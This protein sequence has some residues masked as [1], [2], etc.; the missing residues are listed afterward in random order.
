MSSERHYTSLD[1]FLCEAQNFLN[2]GSVKNHSASRQNPANR[3]N[4]HALDDAEKNLSA[5]LMRVN[6]AGEVAAQGLY[7]GQSLTAKTQETRRQMRDAAREEGDHLH[8]CA[9]R[10]EELDSHTSYLDPLWYAGSVAIGCIAGKAGDRWSYGFVEETE[11]QVMQHLEGHLEKLPPQ[12]EKSRAI[13]EQMKHD[14][15]EHA[16]KAKAFGASDLPKPVKAL[17]SLTAKVM[18]T[19][20]RYI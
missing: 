16:A 9:E 7:L 19:G 20:A 18:T 3:L 2:L 1:H 6:H 13:I 10:L 5:A 15:A 11:Q 14:E 12:D 4:E 8:W 17:M